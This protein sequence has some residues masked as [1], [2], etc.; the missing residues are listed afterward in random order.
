MSTLYTPPAP[1]VIDWTK[2]TRTVSGRPV[3]IYCTDGG[4]SHCV[5]GAVFV[6]SSDED[7][8]DDSYWDIASWTLGG[9]YRYGGERSSQDLD[10]SDA[11]KGGSL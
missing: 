9:Q 1:T 4:R 3:R 6:A 7:G 2:V 10:L 11:L 5:H 8:N